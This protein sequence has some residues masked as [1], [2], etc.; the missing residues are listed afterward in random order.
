MVAERPAAPSLWLERQE[1]G[2]QIKVPLQGLPAATQPR[3]HVDQS[4]SLASSR[5]HVP[6]QQGLMA[7]TWGL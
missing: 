3:R 5:E 2:L 6:R 1:G 7:E 4:E